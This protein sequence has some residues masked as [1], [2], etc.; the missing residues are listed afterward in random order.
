VNGVGSTGAI[1]VGV[2][3]SVVS[4]SFI[5]IIAGSSSGHSV[6]N[7]SLTRTL[8]VGNGGGVTA[9]GTNAN[10]WL[11]QSTITSNGTGYNVNTGGI[12]NS[13]GDNYFANNPINS[14]ILTGATK[15]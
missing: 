4:N 6:I 13:Y 3:D 1:N 15:Q 9:Q 12:I 5:G 2:M 14:G 8:A 11:A 7:L 10:V